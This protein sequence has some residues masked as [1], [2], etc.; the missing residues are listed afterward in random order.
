M[1][2]RERAQRVRDALATWTVRG[3]AGRTPE[4]CGLPSVDEGIAGGKYSPKVEGMDDDG[5]I[6]V[7]DFLCDLMHYCDAVGLDF[8]GQLNRAEYHYSEEVTEPWDEEVPEGETL[9]ERIDR[10]V[11]RNAVRSA[12]GTLT[13]EERDELGAAYRER[14]SSQSAA[15]AS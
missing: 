10:L 13:D 14:D 5:F 11:R 6:V 15:D 3:Y 8:D 4:E 7:Q 12:V 2:N 1:T 9:E